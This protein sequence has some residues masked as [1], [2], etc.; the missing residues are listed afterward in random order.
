MQVLRKAAAKIKGDSEVDSIK[1]LQ[2]S[3]ASTEIYFP[4]DATLQI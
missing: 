2:E 3:V 1:K 4:I